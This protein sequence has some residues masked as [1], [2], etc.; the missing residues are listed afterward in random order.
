MPFGEFTS[1]GEVALTYQITLRPERL[2]QLLPMTVDESFRRRLEFDRLNAPVTV[3]EQAISEF[4]IAPVLQEMWRAYSD[5]LMIWSHVQF[6]QAQPLKGYS[7]YFFA[8]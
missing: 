2:V 1:L 4:L 3:S 5:A 8:K 6:G 7:D